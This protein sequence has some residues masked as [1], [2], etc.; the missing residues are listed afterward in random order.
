MAKLEKIKLDLETYK[1]LLKFHDN[2][3][4]I[5]IHFDTPSRRFYFALIALIV[6]EMKD[7]NKAGYIHIR[8]HENT[9]KLLDKSLAGKHV[10]KSAE[11]MWIKIRKAWRDRLPDLETAALFKII[12]RDL[13]A[14][15]EKGGK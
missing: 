13:I 14:P 5:S 2:K 9:L 6:I 10:S 1:I 3:E 12:N 4:S 11:D 15:Y 7:L 8:K